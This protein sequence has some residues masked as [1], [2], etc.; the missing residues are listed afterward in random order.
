MSIVSQ[1]PSLEPIAGAC[2]AINLAY[3]GLRRFRY[4]S[5]IREHARE[6][7]KIIEPKNGDAQIPEVIESKLYRGVMRLAR[8]TDND[9]REEKNNKANYG[10]LPPGFWGFIYILFFERHQD[11]FFAMVATVWAMAALILGVAHSINHMLFALPLFVDGYELITF[12][13]L[14][15]GMILPVVFVTCGKYVVDWGCDMATDQIG[16]LEKI[17]QGVARNAALRNGGAALIQ[18]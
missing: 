8:L 9:L 15:A 7:L 6:K 11:R 5:K 13:A 12:Y 4:R 1:L 2:L 10:S 16:D 17:M 3:L 14:S 18:A